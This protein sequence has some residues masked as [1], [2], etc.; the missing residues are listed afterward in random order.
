MIRRVTI[1]DLPACLEI[2]TACYRQKFDQRRAWEWCVLALQQPDMCGVME[3]DAFA[4]AAVR[5]QFW[6]PPDVRH[7]VMIFM[8]IRTPWAA[9]QGVRCLRVLRDWAT[10]LMGAVDFGFGE[11]TG[12]DFSP[13]AKRIGAV[14]N[15]PTYIYRT[16]RADLL[17]KRIEK[18]Y[19]ERKR[20]LNHMGAL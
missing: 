15:R 7:G 12:L 6:E 20:E 2:A 4:V 9:Q 17:D 10:I 5:S 16:E 11:D 13:F 14:P 8:A 1:D 18:V 19:P 3:D